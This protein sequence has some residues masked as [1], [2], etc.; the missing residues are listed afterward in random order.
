[1][2]LDRCLDVRRYLEKLFQAAGWHKKALAI[3]MLDGRKRASAE[4]VVR[5]LFFTKDAQRVCRRIFTLIAIERH[6]ATRYS[7][8]PLEQ[9]TIAFRYSPDQFKR[10]LDAAQAGE[11]IPLVD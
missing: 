9:F 4:A 11:R 6:L 2:V 5:D 8:N 1:M 10:V 7:Y 3:V